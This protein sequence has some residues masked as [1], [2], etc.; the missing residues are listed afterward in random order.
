MSTKDKP[1]AYV[2]ETGC[3]VIV[4]E[5]TFRKISFIDH[6]R[7]IPASWTPLHKEDEENKL[8]AVC[9][10]T[11]D[12]DGIWQADC[13]HAFEFTHG[14]PKEN[15]MVFCAYCGKKLKEGGA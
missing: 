13:G 5:D 12:S 11:C 6:G 8:P 2:D 14:G 4:G 3:I 1:D 15:D 10:W 9:T 7:A